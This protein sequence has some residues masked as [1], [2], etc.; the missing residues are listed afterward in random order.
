MQNPKLCA[1]QARL[2]LRIALLIGDIRIYKSVLG[3]GYQSNLRFVPA[4]FSHTVQIHGEF[5]ASVKEQIKPKVG[6]F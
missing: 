4:V 2:L 3:L 5:R 1:G 6:S